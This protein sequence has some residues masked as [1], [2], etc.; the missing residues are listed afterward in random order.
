MSGKREPTPPG[1]VRMRRVVLDLGDVCTPG[2]AGGL[3]KTPEPLSELVCAVRKDAG[4]S[5]AK[6]ARLCATGQPRISSIERGSGRLPIE[7]L[8]RVAHAVGKRVEITI[9]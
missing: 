7:L 3:R 9:R 1:A 4:L 5:Q 2:E 6:L 8:V